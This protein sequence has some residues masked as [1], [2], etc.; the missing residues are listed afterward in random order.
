M[1]TFEPIPGLIFT[2]N[3]D[4]SG[5]VVSIV[6]PA[7]NIG[8]VMV[9]PSQETAFDPAITVAQAEAAVIFLLTTLG[10]YP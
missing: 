4:S 2:F 3:L 5:N 9:L 8:P 10:L 7:I 1:A 6:T